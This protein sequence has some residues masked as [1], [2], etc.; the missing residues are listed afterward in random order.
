MHLQGIINGKF[1]KVRKLYYTNLII[2][3]LGMT[4]TFEFMKNVPGEMLC[5]DRD[6]GMADDSAVNTVIPR[7]ACTYLVAGNFFFL[8]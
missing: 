1:Q 7:S 3:D 4:K 5:L 2:F 6:D 8:E